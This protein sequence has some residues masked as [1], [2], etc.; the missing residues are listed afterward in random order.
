MP[1]CVP[2][3]HVRP[4]TLQ[5]RARLSPEALQAF[6]GAQ[7]PAVLLGIVDDGA[8]H[9]SGMVDAFATALGDAV[10]ELAS[11]THRP[12]S[13]AGPQ[14]QLLAPPLA[15]VD[16]ALG[17]VRSAGAGFGAGN[18]YEAQLMSHMHPLPQSRTLGVVRAS[19]W[20]E[21]GA[22]NAALR[23]AAV[24]CDAIVL[25]IRPSADPDMAAVRRV[26]TA[27]RDALPGRR[28]RRSGSAHLWVLAELSEQE[29]ADGSWPSAQLYRRAFDVLRSSSRGEVLDAP[30][31]SETSAPPLTVRSIVR[32]SA[33]AASVRR[34]ALTVATDVVQAT[35]D[36]ATLDNAVAAR[37]ACALDAAIMN[38]GT[39]SSGPGEGEL[40]A[41]SM[42]RVADMYSIELAAFRQVAHSLS[43]ADAGAETVRAAL[44][45][46]AKATSER[47]DL[48]GSC[49]GAET[50][51]A[52]KRSRLED[53]LQAQTA[54]AADDLA[55]FLDEDVSLLTEPI[56]QGFATELED[57]LA[58]VRNMDSR[59]RA[60]ECCA[61][62]IRYG[63]DSFA[64]ASHVAFDA[65]VAQ[66]RAVCAAQIEC[67]AGAL[68]GR[69]AALMADSKATV[70]S[71]VADNFHWNAEHTIDDT[72]TEVRAEMLEAFMNALM[73]LATEG[74]NNKNGEVFSARQA[75]PDV[76]R[77]R[78]R[79]ENAVHTVRGWAGLDERGDK[80]A[81]SSHYRASKTID[82]LES[83]FEDIRVLSSNVVR[84][85]ATTR[86]A[87][88]STDS[89]DDKGDP[90]EAGEVA[91][92]EAKETLVSCEL[93]VAEGI[94]NASFLEQ[95]EQQRLL[96]WVADTV[97][98]VR[99]DI[100]AMSKAPMAHHLLLMAS[101]YHAKEEQLLSSMI[102]VLDDV[103][104]PEGASIATPA[105]YRAHVGA[106]ALAAKGELVRLAWVHNRTKGGAA[107][108]ESLRKVDEAIARHKLVYAR[109]V[110]TSATGVLALV[111]LALACAT[112]ARRGAG[113]LLTRR[114]H[115]D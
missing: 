68:E 89:R 4:R 17:A 85:C 5:G 2:P 75:I 93:R 87:Y 97:E 6:H 64:N 47:W 1:P 80:A 56:V 73:P 110:S 61:P 23:A 27:A 12:V 60:G 15:G 88:A 69:M 11:Q 98:A 13:D 33:D 55:A 96:V 72:G 83:V 94:R 41:V 7:Q 108:E 65:H 111:V 36:Q 91:A 103:V 78:A 14:R 106:V 58:A 3:T 99:A 82:V 71:I 20:G 84:V 81:R 24:L 48:L 57:A 10:A 79:I 67:D 109:E 29:M 114:G 22:A 30:G 42:M 25:R 66:L 51:F 34:A 35:L 104:R 32:A 18:G 38:S 107:L 95:S 44:G 8:E 86:A 28:L 92:L 113:G 100:A 39:S 102:S 26:V 52:A 9:S 21:G 70:A 49:Y 59:Q 112:C 105:E 63:V 31:E 77:A 54:R 62:G 46:A 19:V 45:A 50:A 37:A 115:E 76:K 43:D 16:P 101:K 53:A 90:W 74:C 40:Q